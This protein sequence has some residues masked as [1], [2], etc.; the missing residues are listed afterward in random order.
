MTELGKRRYPELSEEDIEAKRMKIH[1]TNKFTLKANQ[2]AARQF[3]DFLKEKDK[4][5]NFEDYGIPKLDHAL[6]IIQPSWCRGLH[7]H[8]RIHLIKIFFRYRRI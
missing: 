1:S 6:S 7:V 3:K 4:D 8:R 2:G 5:I